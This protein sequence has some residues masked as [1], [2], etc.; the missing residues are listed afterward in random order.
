MKA[1]EVKQLLDTIGKDMLFRKTGLI[2]DILDDNPYYQGT[3]SN[4][5]SYLNKKMGKS[6]MY[7]KEGAK[8][9]LNKDWRLYVPIGFKDIIRGI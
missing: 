3:V 2:L 1:N 7:L 6:P 5:K 9:K 8:S 4:L